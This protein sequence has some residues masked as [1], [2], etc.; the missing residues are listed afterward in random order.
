MCEHVDTY[1]YTYTYTQ[2]CPG[3]G[4]H[5]CFYKGKNIISCDSDSY[6]RY[7]T[8]QP[9]RSL[10]QIKLK[11]KFLMHSIDALEMTSWRTL[12]IIKQNK[13]NKTNTFLSSKKFYY[14][15][16]KA[17]HTLSKEKRLVCFASEVPFPG[18]CFKH[19]LPDGCIIQKALE[20]LGIGCLTGM[21]GA[22]F[23][24]LHSCGCALSFPHHC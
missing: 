20:L 16:Q 9:P 23:W 12:R 2:L 4:I 1:T 13:Q 17:W 18:S 7:T 14:G 11:S 6:I 19:L 22:G 8:C 3:R 15:G 21:L 24:R 5:R 10:L